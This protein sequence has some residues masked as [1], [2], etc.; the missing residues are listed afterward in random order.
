MK[1]PGLVKI[2][3]PSPRPS[4]S[5]SV[6]VASTYSTRSSTRVPLYQN[7]GF[8]GI[9]MSSRCKSA[10]ALMQL[11]TYELT[12][13]SGAAPASAGSALALGRAV[14]FGNTC[15]PSTGPEDPWLPWLG[16]KLYELFLDLQCPWACLSR[17]SIYIYTYI[18]IS[19]MKACM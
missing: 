9:S 4:I 1:A 10:F 8:A 5:A 11:C 16:C 7:Q 17:S 2:K 13:G 12:S 18:Y 6:H 15:S 3:A 19:M 14:A